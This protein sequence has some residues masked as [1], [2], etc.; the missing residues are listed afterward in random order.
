LELGFGAGDEDE[1]EAL[2]GELDGIF[3][4]KTIGGTC[5]QGP[6]SFLAIFS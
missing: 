6:G 4:S 1:V 2:L 3:F 5:Y